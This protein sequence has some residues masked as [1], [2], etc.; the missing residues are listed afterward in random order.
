MEDIRFGQ[1]CDKCGRPKI[2]CVCVQRIEVKRKDNSIDGKGIS[3]LLKE[4]KYPKSQ[5]TNLLLEFGI[6]IMKQ[7]KLETIGDFDHM[8]WIKEHIDL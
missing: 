6:E 7:V 1:I 5:V 8:K 2:S 3:E 4:K